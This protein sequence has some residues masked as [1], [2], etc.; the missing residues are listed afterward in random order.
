MDVAKI[1]TPERVR[2][3]A[4]VGSKKHALD[5]LSQ[6][7]SAAVGNV[8]AGRILEGLAARE[9][10]GST[11]LGAS[12]AMPHTRLGGI[13][14]VTGAFLRLDEPVPFD[15]LDQR[16]VDLLFGLV[17]PDGLRPAELTE[18]RELV[19]TLKSPELQQRL[20]AADGADELYDVLTGTP[21][22]RSL[23]PAQRTTGG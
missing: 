22:V 1:V 23:S 17:V 14:K 19:K 9:R 21:T 3:E 12:V 11:G 10:L 18:V 2:C 16:P 7:L 6:M 20:R 5:V 4:Q 13:D 15:S 8:S